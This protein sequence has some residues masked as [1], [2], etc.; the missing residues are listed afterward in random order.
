MTENLRQTFSTARFRRWGSFVGAAMALTSTLTPLSASAIR[1]DSLTHEYAMQPGEKKQGSFVITNTSNEP[2]EIEF[3]HHDYLPTTNGRTEQPAIGS[4]S[5]SNGHWIT[6]APHDAIIPPKTKLQVS[7]EISAPTSVKQGAYW[8]AFTILPTV[9]RPNEG[10]TM[11]LMQRTGY[12]VQVISRVGQPS[13]AK[14]DV[15]A[16][17]SENAHN[18]QGKVFK[19]NLKNTSNF[20]VPLASFIEVFSTE[21][22]IV[23]R[24]VGTKRR[25]YPGTEV[26]YNFSVKEPIA[27]GTYTALITLDDGGENYFGVQKKLTVSSSG[28][29][30]FN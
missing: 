19:M 11:A 30:T 4:A 6:I 13:K 9:K 5:S 20:D 25:V 17:S 21:G 22:T 16:L 1:V 24:T 29:Y 27:P 28:E 10:K 23:N 7:Y 12:V 18:N 3:K 14:I 26:T 15:T 2:V 8:S